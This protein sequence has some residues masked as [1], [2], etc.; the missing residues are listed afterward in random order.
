M[1]PVAD[2]SDRP[3]N[4]SQVPELMLDLIAEIT[5]GFGGPPS[6][7]EVVEVISQAM[8]VSDERLALSVM[9]SSLIVRS[10][11]NR[12]KKKISRVAQLNDSAFVLAAG[13][14]SAQLDEK[15][16]N[17]HVVTESE[18]TAWLVN[19]LAQVPAGLLADSAAD[20]QSIEL[21]GLPARKRPKRGDVVAIPSAKGGFHLA[22]VLMKN[23]FGVA[24]GLFTRR[25]TALRMPAGL[26]R[27]GVLTH[28]VYSG[29]RAILAGRWIT[30]GHDESLCSLFPPEPEIYHRLGIAETASGV[31]RPVP[32]EELERVGVLDGSYSQVY[33]DSEL[34]YELDA[35]KIVK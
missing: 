14:I 13:L 29:E 3:R 19:L 35:G 10:S 25:R 20:V 30:V 17:G 1:H 22:V 33:L 34:E 8:P 6:V 18:F 11:S 26:E 5:E 4:V 23:R 21:I 7:S 31:T 27:E 28:A 15:S 24:F 2:G 16:T 32:D 9:P 12:P